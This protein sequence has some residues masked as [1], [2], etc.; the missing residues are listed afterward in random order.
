MLGD[1]HGQFYDLLRLFDYGGEAPK[2]NYLFLG[3]YV[4][5][6][7]N[8]LVTKSLL[9]FKSNLKKISIY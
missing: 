5:Q 3:D 4:D 8:S 1:T 2:G 6:G 9:P 7:K